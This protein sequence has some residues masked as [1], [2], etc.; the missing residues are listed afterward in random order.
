MAIQDPLTGLIIGCCFRVASELGP[1]L[2]EKGYGNAFAFELRE[3]KVH[4]VQQQSIEIFYRGAKVG[5]DQADL[6]VDPDPP[7]DGLGRL[8]EK[9]PVAVSCG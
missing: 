3:A 4:F 9:G 2:L 5:H 6:I 8:G 7:E 1:G